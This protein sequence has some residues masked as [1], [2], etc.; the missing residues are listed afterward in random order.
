[1]IRTAVLAAVLACATS[2][3]AQVAASPSPNAADVL[4]FRRI[5]APTDRK[6]DWPFRDERYLPIAPQDFNKAIEQLP[7]SSAPPANSALVEA[8][9]TATFEKPDRLSGTVEL[10]IRPT[11]GGPRLVPL[12]AVD[13]SLTDATWK[14][15]NQPA[16]IGTSPEGSAAV[17]VERGGT[18]VGRWSLRGRND[19][20]G[21]MNFDLASFAAATTSLT[22][23]IP[24]GYEIK[25]DGSMLAADT[26]PKNGPA[27]YVVQG[28]S[29]RRRLRISAAAATGVPQRPTAV[30]Q[31]VDYEYAERGIDV[32]AQFRIDAVN[33]PLERIEIELDPSL[34]LVDARYGEKR[35]SWSDVVGA[36]PTPKRVALEFDPP[37][38]GVGRTVMLRALAPA[39][40]G[41][42]HALPIIRCPDLDWRQGTMSLSVSSP[43]AVN[44]ID[45]LSCSSAA[46]TPIAG[47]R[48]GEVIEFTC[49]DSRATARVLV[50]RAPDVVDATSVTAVTFGADELTAEYRAELRIAAGER[51]LVQAGVP[52]RWIVDSVS[53][54]PAGAVADWTLSE[55]RD[56]KRWLT[57]RLAQALRADRPLRLLI[58]ARAPRPGAGNIL[59]QEDLRIV[60]FR[61]ARD[62]A[63]A[64]AIRSAEMWRLELE[65]ERDEA[66]LS[67]ERLDPLRRELLGEFA[68]EFLV[69]LRAFAEPW[70]L[71]MSRRAARVEANID[72]T[73]V[74]AAAGLTEQYRFKIKNLDE[75]SLDRLQVKF[76]PG[77]TEPLTWS[78]SD[79]HQGHVDARRLPD[80]KSSGAE[81]WELT[82]VEPPG[83]DFE[84]KAVRHTPPADEYQVALAAVVDAAS[85]TGI[86]SV[87]TD[88]TVSVSIDHTT[89]GSLA[90][91]GFA[92]VGRLVRGRYA[93]IPAQDVSPEV[94][95]RLNL[96]R[97]SNE[98]SPAAVVWLAD[99]RSQ[100][101]Q[102]GLARHSIALRIQSLG[103][104]KLHWRFPQEARR[105]SI[106]VDDSPFVARSADVE[107]PLP[108]RREMISVTADYELEGSSGVAVRELKVADI[109]LDLPIFR[110]RRT[111]DLPPDFVPLQLAED[112]SA[113]TVVTRLL[114]LA[115]PL[116]SPSFREPQAKGSLLQERRLPIASSISGSKQGI[117]SLRLETS[118]GL[119]FVAL[120]V[121][122]TVT[123]YCLLHRPRAFW[124]A[125][126]VFAALA[127]LL[128]AAVAPL[129]VWF[130][131]GIGLCGICDVILPGIRRPTRAIP[132]AFSA[133]SVRQGSSVRPTFT[134]ILLFSA[135]V[136]GAADTGA[137]TTPDEPV[138]AV[139]I[140]VDEKGRETGER[141]LVP[142]RF[143]K[144]LERR[145][146]K[147][148]SALSVLI[149]SAEYAVDLAHDALRTNY[150]VTHVGA[151]WR[152]E[153]LRNQVELS[154]P[155]NPFSE[156]T[157][158]V[159]LDGRPVDVVRS[160]NGA[161]LS[162]AID[163]AGAHE[164]EAFAR[165]TT[166]AAV[167]SSRFAMAVPR[168]LDTTVKVGAPPELTGLTVA[169]AVE[170][171]TSSPDRRTTLF[172]ATPSDA[173]TLSWE[174]SPA[175]GDQVGFEQLEYW[176]IRP[177]SVTVDV[178]YR[179]ASKAAGAREV[180]LYGDPRL[181]WLTRRTGDERDT[182]VVAAPVVVD[183]ATVGQRLRLSR[184]SLN[185]AD[186]VIEASFL[187]SGATGIGRMRLPELRIDGAA[188]KR[189]LIAVAIDAG[190]DFTFSGS[191]GFTT[192]AIPEF[193]RS[194]GGPTSLPQGAF[195]YQGPTDD[196]GVA[197]RSKTPKSEATS[198]QTLVCGVKRIEI[199]YDAT[200]TVAGDGLSHHEIA[201]PPTV[202][203]DAV[204]I[205]DA[206]GEEQLL[207][208]SRDDAA[209]VVAFLRAPIRGE[210]RINLKGRLPVPPTRR[211]PLPMIT[212][213]GAAGGEKRIRIAR[214]PDAVTAITKAKQLDVV[215]IDSA[216]D[217]GGRG[218][219]ESV[220]SVV[221]PQ[222]SAE[223]HITGNDPVVDAAVMNTLRRDGTAW[224]LELVAR[225]QVRSGLLDE[226]RLDLPSTI[227]TPL[228]IT[229][230]MPYEVA[231]LRDG[232]RRLVLHPRDA[233]RGEY[234]FALRSPLTSLDREHPVPYIR[235]RQVESAEYYFQL[236]ARSGV[237]RVD[238][239]L[240][241][242]IVAETPTGFAKPTTEEVVTFRAVGLQPSA[243]L[244]DVRRTVERPQVRLADYRVRLTPEGEYGV[245]TFLVESSGLSEYNLRF[246]RGT[247]PLA[248]RVGG[249]DLTPPH[250]VG[251]LLKI[252]AASDQMPH[253]LEV[254]YQRPT[255]AAE[256]GD[257]RTLSV[258]RLEGLPVVKTLWSIDVDAALGR[259][260]LDNDARVN[261][262]RTVQTRLEAYE[263]VSAELS[264][265]GGISV[266]GDWAVPLA[267]RRRRAQRDLDRIAAMTSAGSRS[268]KPGESAAS[269]S[270]GS[271]VYDPR[272]NFDEIWMSE[273]SDRAAK[274]YLLSSGPMIV[275]DLRPA[276]TIVAAA[277]AQL[278]APCIC[279]LLAIAGFYWGRYDGLSRWSPYLCVLIGIT[280]IVF[281]QPA[282][283]GW[284][285]IVA[286]LASRL[287]PSLRRARDR[288]ASTSIPLRLAR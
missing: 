256:Y 21:G 62:D 124:S 280:W 242:L 46:P 35:L 257:L 115:G 67:A 286:A 249:A 193:E 97:T 93:Y 279:L 9:L 101:D 189:R 113:E 261:E 179:L 160:D 31:D 120:A 271:A 117:W 185:E 39:Q 167:A 277:A 162:I 263:A 50:S 213:V 112:E 283:V 154:L 266:V 12:S 281:L 17:W 212:V 36:K 282:I 151:K 145:T 127:M 171:P 273:R 84:L 132:T 57:I 95:A 187:L 135:T 169:E 55:I 164:V 122:V 221:G 65:L 5:L 110:L 8:R 129:P 27:T 211:L 118:L 182:T 269:K 177:G 251:E 128:P 61:D 214:L 103:A 232:K 186:D 156:S 196:W 126:A 225:L 165:P 74:V 22:L 255:A 81:I 108:N 20:A 173:L 6:Q 183:Q 229:P 287:H 24:V 147:N 180:T 172:R 238:W 86:A 131:F 116:L 168:V 136:L 96:H 40:V 80:A 91:N 10:T 146:A 248:I 92:E 139:F 250:D 198:T 64:A 224:E 76:Q 87:E 66:A 288:R 218:R 254:L 28:L 47:E 181:Q 100:Y 216:G 105:L 253:V 37:L 48:S 270:D 215:P 111:V 190:L 83:K 155:F 267:E 25:I 18:I 89:L 45:A 141:Y 150:L 137:Q 114:R 144:S 15:G 143:W 42:R 121:G 276:T 252:P 52:T 72:V 7:G 272:R 223:L 201:V 125:V 161:T 119:C 241:Q 259:W 265:D 11:G 184:A 4:P 210:H 233:I 29:Q 51:F 284:I 244:R 247:M 59:R 138:P 231:T 192:L 227:A 262:L 104:E 1:M 77:R 228:T 63:P 16:V 109:D 159:L 30:R 153:T 217:G 2:A 148:N 235:F 43:L 240:E 243:V 188:A 54:V 236:P 14:A 157:L 149:R 58:L 73:T 206:D 60:E 264:V 204:S 200:V 44:R 194:W 209:S 226:I 94:S 203:V 79:K 245:A 222:P 219:I 176:R 166:V 134:S 170:P 41:K 158:A 85:Q 13:F 230:A 274:F 174:G 246:E 88:A 49:F 258:P 197:L 82:F 99:V 32:T 275:A 106:R 142:E 260:T 239:E 34:T 75:T 163:T 152:V 130:L 107:I 234:Q 195:E 202:D 3:Q 19:P 69:D 38:F 208:W 199:I 68:P 175:G 23:T 205:V 207:R 178:K 102:S 33:E 90:V 70:R 53:S 133:D 71:R 98:R 268:P 237:N 191:K 140:P 56:Q 278:A 78:L 285:F 220:L 26:A 123:Y